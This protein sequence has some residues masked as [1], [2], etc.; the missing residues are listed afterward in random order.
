M[1]DIEVNHSALMDDLQSKVSDQDYESATIIA[2]DLSNLV[3]AQS[4]EGA[5]VFA[6]WAVAYAGLH[7]AQTALFIAEHRQPFQHPDYQL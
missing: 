6:Q 1:T 2:L 4:P 3:G 7:Q 5:L